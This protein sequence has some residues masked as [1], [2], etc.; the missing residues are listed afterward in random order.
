[1]PLVMEVTGPE[2]FWHGQ[3]ELGDKGRLQKTRPSGS[4]RLGGGWMDISMAQLGGPEARLGFWGLFLLCL[5]SQSSG[6]YP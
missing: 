5:S 6:G 3:T 1:M 2:W 4:P